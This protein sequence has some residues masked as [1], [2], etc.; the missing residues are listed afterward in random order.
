MYVTGHL[1][2]WVLAVQAYCKDLV[3]NNPRF[4]F[5]AHTGLHFCGV[6]FLVFKGKF[7]TDAVRLELDKQKQMLF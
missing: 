4:S 2:V 1:K 7:F 3:Q 5:R 6:V